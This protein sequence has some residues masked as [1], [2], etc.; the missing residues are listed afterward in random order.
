MNWGE[1]TVGRINNQEVDYY[2][3]GMCETWFAWKSS[4]PL[5]SSGIVIQ[6][7]FFQAKK[8]EFLAIC[9]GLFSEQIEAYNNTDQYLWSF[10]C[11]HKN[12]SMA[13]D[14]IIFL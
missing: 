2:W 1:N 9:V 5:L 11:V 7:Y 10:T 3:H 14:A 13:K 12:K 6:L 4:F 8:Q